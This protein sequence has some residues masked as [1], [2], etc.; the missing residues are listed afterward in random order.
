MKNKIAIKLS[1]YF[2]L[3][4][5]IFSLIIGGVFIILFRNHTI[6]L[7]KNDLENRAKSISQTLSGFLINRE[8][9]NTMHE[10]GS[11]GGYGAYLR[12]I[13]DIA[14]TNVWI[15]D[16]N[17]NL[18]TSGTHHSNSNQNYSYKDLPSNA[19]HLVKEVFTNK[20][21]FSEDFSGI[22]SEST[23]TIGTPIKGNDNQVIGAVL[24]HSPVHGI[25][26]TI[27]EGGK[28][29]IISLCVA[30]FLVFL[31]SLWL[32]KNFTD[33]IISKEAD[34][35]LRLENVRREF[36]ANISHE[37][38][39]P[40]TVIR[41]SLEAL[42]D[43]VITNPT[44]IEDYHCQMLEE[45]IF[46][47]RLIGDLLD[48]SKLQNYDYIIEK[49]NVSIN[50][51]LEDVVRSISPIALEK[52]VKLII[53]KS[54]N[55]HFIYGDYGRLR[56]MLLIIIDNAI[57]FSPSNGEVDITLNEKKIII[58]DNGIGISE[59]ELPHI[60]DRFYKSRS[61]Q[62]KSGTGLGLAIAKQIADRHNIKISVSSN[63]NEGTFFIFEM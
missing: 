63:I 42:I 47:Q 14:G 7:H 51:I 31:L 3:V 52:Q 19:E 33:P 36:I 50:N 48:L 46:L 45:T 16:K 1:L 5:I 32:S 38:K 44:Q 8:N 54:N 28:L 53:K 12:F 62:N 30:L 37:L 34:N 58:H 15:V 61:E 40:V 59:S 56:Q 21:V 39:T 4:L 24:L 41:G 2:A 6:N 55:S 10:P 13:E 22:L 57:K 11:M 20:T 26:N 25:N 43:K 17:L 23:L 49:Q 27:F 9:T 35:A 29:L 60:F 18:L